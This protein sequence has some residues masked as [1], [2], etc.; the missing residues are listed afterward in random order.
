MIVF[1]RDASVK[2]DRVKGTIAA[3]LIMDGGG[4]K[5]TDFSKACSIILQPLLDDVLYSVFEVRVGD[6][7]LNHEMTVFAIEHG[8]VE[9]SYFFEAFR[10]N[11]NRESALWEK[12][13]NKTL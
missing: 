5:E 13:N 6:G 2:N 9:V 11:L 7:V 1:S 3:P 12:N 10:G 4:Y 8:N